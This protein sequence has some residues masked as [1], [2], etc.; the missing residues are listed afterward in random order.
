VRDDVGPTLH[1][2]QWVPGTLFLGVK[3]PRHEADDLAVSCANVKNEWTYT[4]S[5][6]VCLHGMYKD[7]CTFIFYL[8]ELYTAWVVAIPVDISD[9]ICVCVSCPLIIT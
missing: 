4:C 9:K 1:P 5:P 2:F 7:N 3:Q 6:P 8:K